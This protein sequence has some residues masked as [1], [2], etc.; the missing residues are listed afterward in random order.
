M[1]KVIL[2]LGLL[3]GTIVFG[4][5][6]K[7]RPH[8]A[9]WLDIKSYG[10]AISSN[11]IHLKMDLDSGPRNPNLSEW[12]LHFRVLGPI[13]NGVTTLSP[14]DL[15]KL[16]FVLNRV[17]PNGANEQGIIPSVGNIGAITTF[18]PFSE[19]I[20]G[21]VP[22]S[23]YNLAQHEKYLGIDIIYDIV[24][25]PG[26]WMKRH[27]SWNNFQVN[28]AIE[29]R[30]KNGNIM[31]SGIPANL[32][33][34]MRIRPT[35]TPPV[36]QTYVLTLSPAASNVLLEFK[37]PTDYANGVSVKQERAISVISNTPYSIQVYSLSDQLASNSSTL[38]MSSLKLS[39]KD[40]E[41]G[42]QGP[43]VSLSTSEQ[44]VLNSQ[45]HSTTRWYDL[46]YKITP[47]AINA[48]FFNKP[49]ETYSGTLLYS[50]TPQ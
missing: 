1:N 37:T 45:A 2:L 34:D 33:F 20:T 13:T 26:A 16:G 23:K 6:F 49:Y 17:N 47:P 8:N 43:E 18:V 48:G 50:L 12:S 40:N 15:Q 35:D 7:F 44:A 29:F 31:P 38:P 9:G 28:L 11:L 14:T 30:D 25:Q 27:F 5:D 10:G 24:A 46:Q 39:L 4:Q 22:A 42:I 36:E 19:V 32:S 21:L 41:N 3:L